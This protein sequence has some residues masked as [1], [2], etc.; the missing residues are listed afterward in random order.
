MI[1]ILIDDVAYNCKNDLSDYSLQDLVFI[2]KIPKPKADDKQSLVNYI[3]IVLLL[4]TDIPKEVINKTDTVQFADKYL[5]DLFS[6]FINKSYTKEIR[7]KYFDRLPKAI[8][9]MPIYYWSAQQFCDAID[10]FNGG[11]EQFDLFTAVLLSN[12][13]TQEEA[14]KKA[15]EYKDIKGNDIALLMSYFGGVIDYINNRYEWVLT[16][17]KSSTTDKERNAIKKAKLD[18]F[19]FGSAIFEVTEAG[20]YS[21]INECKHDNVHDFLTAL[22]YVRSCN[23]YK[24]IIND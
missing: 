20:L 19:G 3:D 10:I 11:Y 16:P 13:Y 22:S 12:D 14:S 18:T 1:P 2:E 7:S 9:D 15:N 5:S 24:Q 6:F 21:S 17:F 8:N 23:N 4:I